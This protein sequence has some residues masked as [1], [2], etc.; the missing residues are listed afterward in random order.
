MCNPDCA[1]NCLKGVWLLI[2]IVWQYLR[3]R[4]SNL[5]IR[6]YPP[7]LLDWL[8]NLEVAILGRIL[9][10]EV[11]YPVRCLQW[12]LC[13][14]HESY[15]VIHIQLEWFWSLKL[16]LDWVLELAFLGAFCSPSFL[17][18]S[19]NWL[20]WEWTNFLSS[21]KLHIRKALEVFID[22]ESRF[23]IR[24]FYHLLLLKFEWSRWALLLFLFVLVS[25]FCIRPCS[26][27]LTEKSDR[28]AWLYVHVNALVKWNVTIQLDTLSQ[29]ID[30]WIKIVA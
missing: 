27:R 24:I 17:D 11:C 10:R 16:K 7:K 15:N 5:K 6:N 26:M 1:P 12:N 25:A 29:L 30:F 18:R 28:R 8:S 14:Q 19:I 4:Y 2:E 13:R 23:L 3:D 22:L 20:F 21:K 9:D